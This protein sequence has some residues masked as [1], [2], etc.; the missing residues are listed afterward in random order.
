M[1]TNDTNDTNDTNTPSQAP[2]ESTTNNVAPTSNKTGGNQLTTALIVIIVALLF[3][4]LKTL[5]YEP[6][7]MLSVPVKDYLHFLRIP[8]VHA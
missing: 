1:E 4:M 8:A 6:M 7:P 5:N 2:T 3:V